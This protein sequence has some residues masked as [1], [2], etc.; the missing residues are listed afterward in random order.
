MSHARTNTLHLPACGMFGALFCLAR[1]NS[2]PGHLRVR[3]VTLPGQRA[4][5]GRVRPFVLT[6]CLR[7]SAPR[8]DGGSPARPTSRPARDVTVSLAP[9]VSSAWIR[10]LGACRRWPTFGLVDFI[11][12]VPRGPR[13][14]WRGLWELPTPGVRAS[15]PALSNV[16]SIYRA[17][18]A[19][20]TSSSM[21]GAFI[22]RKIGQRCRGAHQFHDMRHRE[23]D[24]ASR[25]RDGGVAPA[26]RYPTRLGWVRPP[27][28]NRPPSTGRPDGHPPE[29]PGESGPAR[30]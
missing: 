30:R 22:L 28:P 25:R 1:L 20:A 12:P 24:P 13:A 7:C 8:G 4:L 26:R 3:P 21:A 17:R 2:A 19:A 15:R 6:P 23:D 5:V 10:D 16:V 29:G 27:G 11:T 14:G 9:V 18:V